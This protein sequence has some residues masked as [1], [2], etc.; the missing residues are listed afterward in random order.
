MTTISAFN[1]LFK[2]F[3]TE[4]AETFPEQQR[5]KAFANGFDDLVAAN[6]RKIMEVFVATLA[7][8]S[9]LVMTKNPKLFDQPLDIG[10]DISALWKSPDVSENTRE[11]VWQY[12]HS[13]F[14]LGTTCMH[15]PPE[16][17]STIESVAQTCASRMQDGDTVDMSSMASMFVNGLGSIIGGG[18]GGGGMPGVAALLDAPRNTKA[19]E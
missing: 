3:V 11:A 10:V 13:L 16:L 8:H 2:T 9:D 1:T 4:L 14:L 7:P 15:V 17:L 19:G 5:L 12:I 6:A 18:G